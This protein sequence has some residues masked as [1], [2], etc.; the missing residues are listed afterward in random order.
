MVVGLVAVQ[1]RDT[2]VYGDDEDYAYKYANDE[3]D[4]DVDE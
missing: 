2:G 1:Y 4:E 3:S